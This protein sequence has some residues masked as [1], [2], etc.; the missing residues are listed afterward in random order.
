LTF[1]KLASKG[2]VL[3]ILG[4]ERKLSMVDVEDVVDHVLLLADKAE[5]KGEAFF[6]A[7]EESR[8]L[9]GMMREIAELLGVKARTVPVPE[10]LL[11]GIG[12]AADV[13]SNTTGNALPINRKLARQ[14]LVPGW[15]CS[16]EK[17][18]RVLGWAPKVSV[19]DSLKRSAE[20]YKALGWI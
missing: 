19:H 14:L 1:F 17:S 8:S 11:R 9:E 10:M 7:A 16:I 18:K 3:K 5:A 4:P 6:C 2:L 15:E 13:V 12:A 20:S